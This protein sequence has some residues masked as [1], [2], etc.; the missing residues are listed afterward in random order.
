[1]PMN[2]IEFSEQA[3]ILIGLALAP[4][5]V[6]MLFYVILIFTGAVLVAAV[7]SHFGVGMHFQ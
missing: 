5:L 3:A 2:T 7:G 4:V 1:M 6:W